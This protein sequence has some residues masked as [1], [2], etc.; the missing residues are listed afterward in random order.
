MELANGLMIAISEIIATL[1]NFL[2]L[3]HLLGFSLSFSENSISC[4][5]RQSK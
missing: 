5:N 2:N 1:V 3:D 4:S